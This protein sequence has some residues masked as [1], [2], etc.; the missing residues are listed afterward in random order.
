VWHAAAVL[1]L[2]MFGVGQATAVGYAILYHA[3]Q[4]VPITLVGWLF[5]VREHMTLGEATRV[6]TLETPAT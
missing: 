4:F 3:S 1:A 6:P 2:S 5:L